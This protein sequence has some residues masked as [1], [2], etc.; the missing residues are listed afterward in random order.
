M[1][2]VEVAALI[3]SLPFQWVSSHSAAENSRVS[4]RYINILLVGTKEKKAEWWETEMGPQS[5]SQ[6]LTGLV[7][8]EDTRAL[9]ARKILMFYASFFF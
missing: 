1:F 9:R 3:S 5:C 2:T 4:V 6:L 7:M 8:S